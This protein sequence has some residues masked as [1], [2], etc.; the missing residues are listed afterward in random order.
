MVGYSPEKDASIT[1]IQEIPLSL[2]AGQV[3]EQDVQW[4]VDFH[5]DP[6]A[7]YLTRLVLLSPEKTTLAETNTPLTFA[8]LEL[9]ITVSPTDLTANTQTIISV[10]VNNP[11][12]TEW[13][14]NCLPSP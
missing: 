8:Q 13:K 4:R 2:A 10:R 12:S 5:P 9:T 11:G 14:G 7:K 3:F 1:M 6:N